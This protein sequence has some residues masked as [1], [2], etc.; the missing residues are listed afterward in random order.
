MTAPA[1]GPIRVLFLC[2]ANSARS[3][4]AEALLARRG[5]G[6]F[7]VASAGTEPGEQVRSEAL[8]ALRE[9]GIDWSHGRP[10]GL[11]AVSR[12][13]WDLVITLCDRSRET[14]PRVPGRPIYTHWGVPDPATAES[15]R[16]QDAF[17]DTVALIAWRIDLMLAL[18]FASLEELAAQ[19]RLRGI[20]QASPDAAA[21]N[22]GTEAAHARKRS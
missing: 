3:Q 15:R 21:N 18:P 8:D 17:R 6:A 16:R 7:I 14:C 5:R 19:E 11:D 20:G 13:E 1:H 10:K 22:P 2:T 9:I 4:I 12:D